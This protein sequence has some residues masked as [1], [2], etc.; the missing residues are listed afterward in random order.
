MSLPAIES[1]RDLHIWIVEVRGRTVRSAGAGVRSLRQGFSWASTQS[2]SPHPRGPGVR[3]QGGSPEWLLGTFLCQNLEMVP[4]PEKA[5]GNFF[6]EHCYIVLH[7]STG[8]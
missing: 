1:H 7:V 6:E 3:V 2:W 8:E 4:V 5:Y